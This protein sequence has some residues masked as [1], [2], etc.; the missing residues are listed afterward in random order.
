MGSAGSTGSADMD[1]GVRVMTDLVVCARK[2]RRAGG[3]KPARFEAEPG[4]TKYLFVPPDQLPTPEHQV[5]GARWF[6]EAMGRAMARSED[7]KS[8]DI[9]V[10]VHGY[11]NGFDDVM[12]RH[13]QLQADLGAVGFRGTVVTFGWPSDTS[14]LNYLEDRSDA[15]AVALQLVTG[16][17]HRFSKFQRPDCEVNVHLL[18][19]STGA[20]LVREAF[21][22]AD[23]RAEIAARNWTVS[24]VAFI[25][26]DVSSH[27]MRGDS[28]STS[29]LYRHSVRLTNY[30]NPF[31]SI[32]KL[33]NVK[34]VGVRPRV[35]RVGL[36]DDAPDKCV[37]VDCGD[38]FQTLDEDSATFSGTFNHSWH[39]G[40]R[41]FAKDLMET[42]HGDVD[43]RR[44]STRTVG[45]D[46]RLILK[47]A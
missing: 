15:R 42:L 38:Y 24:Q 28:S 5:P 14:A 32:L 9:L 4:P 33:S 40:D 1:I 13:R 23:D 36:P 11:N 44:I 46:G 30:M 39:I 12:T 31:D 35:G 43:R 26:A 45:P 34:R 2:V 7:G 17:I 6:D 37:D 18:C 29:S 19:H 10:F 21:D 16:V 3:G 41:V 20:F 27:C 22:D 47:G 25:G 8:G